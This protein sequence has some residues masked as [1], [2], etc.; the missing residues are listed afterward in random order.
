MPLQELSPLPPVTGYSTLGATLSGIGTD[1]LQRSRHLQDV[2]S[3]RQFVSG[4]SDKERAF[5]STEAASASSR[6]LANEVE[7]ER[8][9]SFAAGV[10]I[11][12]NE[13]YLD[14]SRRDDK[15]AVADAYRRAQ[16][17]GV[18]KL[19]VE[20]T[21]TPDQDGKPLLTHAE[22][23]DP[24]AVQA[25]KEKLGAIKARQMQFQMAQPANA[26]ATVD[27]LSQQ[28]AQHQSRIAEI[29]ARLDQ[30]ARQ[31]APTDPEV[32]ALA[33]QLAEQAKP[34]SG[35]NR[36]AIAQMLPI[37]QKQLN[38]QAFVQHSQDVQAAT[39]QLDGER[40]AEAT[41][42]QTLDHAMQTGKVFPSR[43]ASNPSALRSP[44][45]A[46]TPRV[47]SAADIA[48][49]MR[50]A[51]G[52]SGTAAP[53]PSPSLAPI[54]N[55]TNNQTIEAGN[56]EARRM[57]HAQTESELNR[58]LEEGRQIDAALSD[59]ASRGSTPGGYVSS[60]MFPGAS[61]MGISHNADP[62][63]AA[64]DTAGLLKQKADNAARVKALQAQLIGPTAATV[65]AP[66]MNTPAT[67]TPTLGAA[68][69]A[70]NWWQAPP[71]F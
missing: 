16:A 22:L 63:G 68:Q 23:N 42:A 31:F 30:P 5:R 46:A 39:R 48:S 3:E 67:S 9:R 55:P 24:T 45:T 19:Y 49:A 60:G 8:Q 28:L 64:K 58:A 1:A 10:Q 6:Q 66:V 11:L 38:D 71:D 62:L 47:A 41:L 13:G 34:G 29:S 33:V 15:Q 56:V 27:S 12:I 2:A 36:E 4:E 7:L 65:T 53:G 17:D 69:G 50:A 37:A 21:T 35:R 26:Q 40:Y 20:L 70:P 54:D 52:G 59:A 51:V 57:L 14:G 32:Q 44:S 61:M 18:D 43:V 25:A